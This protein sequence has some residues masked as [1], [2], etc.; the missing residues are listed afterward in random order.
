M[1]VTTMIISRIG[2]SVGDVQCEGNPFINLGL[3]FG[4]RHEGWLSVESFRVRLAWALQELR[5]VIKC[6]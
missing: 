4:M 1:P 5:S 2:A 3:E 6:G